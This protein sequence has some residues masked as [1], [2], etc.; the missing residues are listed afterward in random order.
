MNNIDEI[1]DL[2]QNHLCVTWDNKPYINNLS[3]VKRELREII[4]GVEQ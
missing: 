4:K 2:I 3:E 1:I